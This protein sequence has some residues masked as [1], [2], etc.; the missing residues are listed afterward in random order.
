MAEKLCLR[1]NDF[2]NNVNN[3]FKGLREEHDFTDVTLACE[4]GQ[5]IE[6]HKVIIAA[7]S[8]L[9]KNILKNNKHPHPLI[10]MRGVKSDILIAILDF[11][12][13]GEANVYQENIDAFI[14]LA[15]ELQL[16][17]LS[18]E[19]PTK[20]PHGRVASTNIK[21]LKELHELNVTRVTKQE[22]V[23]KDESGNGT[24][25]E[26][27]NIS[28]NISSNQL[29]SDDFEHLN[30]Q[31]R[32]LLTATETVLPNGQGKAV[33]CNVCGRKGN[34]RNIK[35]HIESK[36]IEGMSIPC[37]FCEKTFRTR[38]SKR[39]HACHHKS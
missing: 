32:S 14:S 23:P 20:D 31:I 39:Q 4:D 30:E 1:W 8:P 11:F 10:Y 19:G 36:H 17:G 6:A 15:Q 27:E 25:K 5:Q 18:N 22:I 9:F 33:V 37:N 13:A 16:D 21:E 38:M 12:Y 24:F 3:A 26:V 35:D 34:R 7:S 2:Q 28:S 29:L